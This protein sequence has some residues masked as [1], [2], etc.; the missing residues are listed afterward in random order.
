MD[1]HLLQRRTRALQEHMFLVDF[2]QLIARNRIIYKVCGSR[3]TIYQIFI[4]D[5]KDCVCSC[6]DF[7]TRGYVCKHIFCL[8]HRMLRFAVTNE[9]P[10][11]QRIWETA[12]LDVLNRFSSDPL[13][14]HKL[15]VIKV[16]EVSQRDWKGEDC[17]I[18]CEPMNDKEK[19]VYCKAK[20]GKSIHKNCLQQWQKIGK[21]KKCIFCR[22][23][24]L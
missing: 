21:Q 22:S 7:K 1:N 20:C 13:P 10:T 18:C 14:E 2:P 16:D 6:L 15:E 19:L 17:G 8:V 4:S 23:D 24:W 12:S 3:G 11:R 9:F 5:N